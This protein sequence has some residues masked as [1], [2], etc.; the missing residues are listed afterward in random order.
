MSG[1]SYK[2]IYIEDG[3]RVLEV[4]ILPEK[5]CN[6]DCIFCPIG[7]SYNKVDTQQSFDEMNNSLNELESMIENCK[8]ALVYINS[9]GEAFVNSRISD[10]IDLIKSKGVPIRLLS[11]GYLLARD[12]YIQIANKCDEIIGEIK[13]NFRRRFSK[14]FKRP[15]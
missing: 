6:F 13:S 15:N 9:K 12:E 8:A 11:N 10:I 1:F 3:R 7:K 14:K 4:N 5:H 2:N